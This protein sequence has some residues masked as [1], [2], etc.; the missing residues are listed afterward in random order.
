MHFNEEE[1]DDSIPHCDRSKKSITTGSWMG[2]FQPMSLLALQSLVRIMILGT[3]V[4]FTVLLHQ[5][6]LRYRSRPP[7]LNFHYNLPVCLSLSALC[8]H[9]LTLFHTSPI[10][11]LFHITSN[12]LSTCHV[13]H[14]YVLVRLLK[15]IRTDA[16]SSVRLKWSRKYFIFEILFS[17]IRDVSSAVLV[18][19]T[20]HRITLLL[21]TLLH[22]ILNS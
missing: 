10:R 20:T 6:S 19:R 11:V 2:C 14:V 8:F 4:S 13:L 18:D 7:A 17:M 9:P 3:A 5:F 16:L 21:Y 15:T 1:Y 12:V 22:R